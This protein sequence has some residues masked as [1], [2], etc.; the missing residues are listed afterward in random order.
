[1]LEQSDIVGESAKVA[2]QAFVAALVAVAML[3][4]EAVQEHLAAD[5]GGRAAQGSHGHVAAA[6]L[7][8]ITEAAWL[9]LLLHP[10]GSWDDA[11]QVGGEGIRHARDG[12]GERAGGAVAIGDVEGV[13]IVG[14][15]TG[16]SQSEYA[17][18]LRRRV[19]TIGLRFGAG[20]GRVS[21]SR[22]CV[23]A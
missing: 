6:A 14:R 23:E 19:L 15:G 10:G 1:M 3:V 7:H 17:E 18:P 13:G 8:E 4:F 2:E 20:D 12:C 11:R 5:D 22:R 21:S 16:C 9:S